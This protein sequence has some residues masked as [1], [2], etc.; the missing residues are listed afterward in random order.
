MVFSSFLEP[1]LI[2]NQNC[3]RLTGEGKQ[4]SFRVLVLNH[5][6]TGDEV[7]YFLVFHCQA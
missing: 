5:R 2:V 1:Q 7:H 3:T 4:Y 6:E